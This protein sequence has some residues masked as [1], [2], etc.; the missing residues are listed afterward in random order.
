[1]LVENIVAQLKVEADSVADKSSS[2]SQAIVWKLK[3][4]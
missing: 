1:M 4:I 2:E 3:L